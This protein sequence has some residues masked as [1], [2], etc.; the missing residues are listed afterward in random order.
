MHRPVED[1]DR[2]LVFDLQTISTRLIHRRRALAWLAGSGGALILA[3]C[4]GGGSDSSGS[5]SD[6][7]A[8]TTTGTTTTTGGGST[9]SSTSSGGATTTTTTTTTTSGSCIADPA[10]T[11]GPYPADGT[12]SSSG[13]TSNVLTASGIVRSDIRPSFLTSTTV[14][15]G[16]PLA[17][18]LTLTLVNAANGCTPLS[19]Y[20]VYLWH[21]DRDGHYSLYSGAATESYLRGVQVTDADGQVTFTTIFPACY[22]G[23]WPHMHFEVFAST[24]A[25]SSG[26]A[27]LLTSQLAMP[28]DVCTAV[29]NGATGYSTSVTHFAR[30]SLS[31]DNVFGDNTTAQIA[32]Q[33]PS[34]SGSVAGGYTATNTIGISV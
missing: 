3:G 10:E 30:V 34:V 9:T 32:Q 11:A 7:T 18:T 1:H 12:N 20:A 24:A 4:G 8:T 16:V 25:A 14:A 17:L 19:G 22:D 31:S 21:C 33:T 13:T 2:G 29:F 26:R 6:T 15:Q 28:G 5:S 23:R 27:A